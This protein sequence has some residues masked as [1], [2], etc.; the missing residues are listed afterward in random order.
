MSIRL[1]ALASLVAVTALAAGCVVEPARPVVYGPRPAPAYVEVVAPQPPPPMFVENVV[2]RRPGFIWAHGYWRWDGRRYVA[3]RGHW[4]PV[5]PGY[6]Y[7]HPHW[8][9]R[10]DG[11][12]WRVGVW[13]AG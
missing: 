2:E 6:H 5:R 8:E 13:V 7:V 9:Q 3:E 4:E 11:W 12:H 1:V 10:R